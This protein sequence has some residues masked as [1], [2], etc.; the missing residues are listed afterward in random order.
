[1]MWHKSFGASPISGISSDHI[2]G[3]RFTVDDGDRA[4]VS[5]IGVYLPCLEQGIGH[6]REHLVELISE[7]KLLGRVVVMGDFN[8]HL[9]E[10]GGPRGRGNPNL[11]GVMVHE[12]LTR[13]ALSAVSLGSMA[14]GPLYSYHSGETYITVDYIFVD[15][16]AMSHCCT[17][18]EMTLT[19]L[20]IF[21]L[22]W[23]C[24]MTLLRSFQKLVGLSR[25]PGLTG[26][27][28]GRL[29]LLVL[30]HQKFRLGFPHSYTPHMRMLTKS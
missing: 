5:V 24:C 30:L 14:S 25:L 6:Y 18:T 10:L 13:Y 20:T 8:V 4:M 7:S 1:M 22:R 23:V 27:W 3:I 15:A 17:H 28:Q 2:C 9:G 16:D 11:R 19:L 29:M 21:Q 26:I 12:M